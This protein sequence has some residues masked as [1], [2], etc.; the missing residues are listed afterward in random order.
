MDARD[1]RVFE[2]VRELLAIQGM[3]LSMDAVATLAGCSK[4]TLYSRYGCKRELLRQAMR[5]HVSSATS[6]LSS[7]DSKPLRQT[8]VDFAIGY[9]DHRN[10]PKVQQTA[11]LLGASVHEFRDEA[12]FMYH[13]SA[14]ALRDQV[15]EWMQTEIARNR[16]NHDDPHFMAELLLSMISGQD[17]ERQ[18]FHAPHRDDAR[19]RQ[20]WADFAIDAFLR[21]FAR[22]PEASMAP[23]NKN[24][25]R[26]FS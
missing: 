21:A 19:Q 3:R 25:P 1:E 23:E 17:F 26:S 7:C 9:L 14:E 12:R 10:K 5:L 15:A 6:G 20:R 2:A 4:Q 22:T 16:L 8:L 24:N 18:R 13:G 11:Q